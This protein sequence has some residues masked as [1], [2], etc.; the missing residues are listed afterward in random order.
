MKKV[1]ARRYASQRSGVERL[2]VVSLCVLLGR[3]VVT[4]TLPVQAAQLDSTVSR[5]HIAPGA[6]TSLMA[7][8]QL[9]PSQHGTVQR[10]QTFFSMLRQAGMNA[11]D[12][13]KLQKAVRSVYNI[14]HLRIGQPYRLQ[15]TTDGQLCWFVYEINTQHRLVVE[16]RGQTFVGRLESIIYEH[17]QRLVQGTI[18]GS[19]YETLASQGETP[20]IATDMRDIFAREVDF[21][22]DLQAGD[23]FR[24]LIEERYRNGK[25]IGY[26]RILA[27][28]LVNRRQVKQV[29]YYPPNQKNGAYYRPDGRA[30]RHMFL[31]SPLRYS[32]ISSR[33]S[34][35]R[36]HPILKR[37]RPHFGIDYAA[38]LGTPVRS[39]ADGVVAVAQ[40]RGASGNM[41][42][43][44]HDRVYSTYYL[45]LSHFA[46][47]VRVGKRV[48][49]G[50]IIG[51]VGSTGLATGPHLDFRLTKHGKYL[52]PLRLRNIEAPPLPSRALPMFK[53]YAKQVLA[54]F[55]RLAITRQQGAAHRT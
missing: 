24:L 21:Y 22:T 31:R 18:R 20:K 26:H 10:G 30:M 44:G 51:Y 27:A 35:R 4:V 48:V 2:S 19:L 46:R 7:A 52:N 45:H 42:E 54:K 5:I 41:I 50:Q 37:Y 49:Q 53:T 11:A 9:L 3:L 39:V 12:L 1:T 16:R 32:R 55:P 23:T 43:I 34:H 29:V 17:R 47:G 13:I 40:H 28:E 14:R 36:F 33:F 38:P 8:P 15:V 25:R 6:G